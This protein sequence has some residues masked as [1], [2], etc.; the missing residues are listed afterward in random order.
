MRIQNNKGFT[1]IELMVVISIIGLLSS[2]VL[3]SLKDARDKAN[4]TKFRAEVMQMVNALELYKNDNGK[5]PSENLFYLFSSQ[6]S[7][8]TFFV[9]SGPRDLF[10]TTYLG[11]YM[12]KKPE[13]PKN[14][15]NSTFEAFTYRSNEYPQVS[16]NN[17]RCSGDI[18]IPKYVLTIAVDNPILFSEFKNWSNLEIKLPGFGW[19]APYTT[20]RCFSLK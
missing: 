14:S 10:S 19:S 1:L 7:N 20:Y 16:Y 17:Y 6:N 12:N 3:A 5:Y 11:K 9:G 18:N 13:I 15:Y 2:I 8:L 4:V